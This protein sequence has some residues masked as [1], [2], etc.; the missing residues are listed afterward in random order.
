MR[1]KRAA[2]AAVVCVVLAL[3][4]ASAHA[5][6]FQSH[7]ESRPISAIFS[8]SPTL[9]DRQCVGCQHDERVLERWAW[10][11]YP[12]S[13]VGS[14][15][16][17]GSVDR[18]VVGFTERQAKRVR[19]ASRL[20]GLIGPLQLRP[21]SYAPKHSLR[22]LNDLQSRIVGEV[23]TKSTLL[24]SVGVVVKSNCVVVGSEQVRK[25]RERLQE[26]YGA[27]APIRVRYERPPSELSARL[28]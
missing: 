5:S 6:W 1:I 28:G 2:V 18:L 8:S 12:E 9:S 10:K 17:L 24:V 23:L 22:E 11:Y 20:P 27:D 21:F 25:A 7:G 26:L 19:A 15:F 4:G 13:Y 16:I 3:G 14:Y